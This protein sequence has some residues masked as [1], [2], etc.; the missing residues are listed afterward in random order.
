MA[1]QDRQRKSAPHNRAKSFSDAVR[2][3]S[4]PIPLDDAELERF[5]AVIVSRERDTWSPSDV[6]A[7]A[8]MAQIEVEAESL[9]R[10]YLAEGQVIEDAGGKRVINP[11]FSAHQ[12]LL[13]QLDKHRRTLGLTASQKGVSGSRNA[14]RNQQ[15]R[16]AAEKVSSLQGLINTPNSDG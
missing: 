7:A 16:Q 10:M 12:Q 6:F 14:K 2:V 15:D 4:A 5:D 13:A 9:R 1:K 11:A 3:I 8:R